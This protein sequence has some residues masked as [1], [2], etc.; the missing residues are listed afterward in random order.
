[1]IQEISTK[2]DIREYI[3]ST[4]DTTANYPTSSDC[5][6][7]STMKVIDGTNKAVVANMIFNGTTWVKESRNVQS[8]ATITLAATTVVHHAFDVISTAAGAV[9]DFTALGLT[10][11]LINITGVRVKYAGAA[12]PGAHTGYRLHLYHTAPAAIADNAAF[13]LPAADLPKYIGYITTSTLVDLGDNC[14]SID[15]DVDF[16]CRLAGTSLYGIL[17]CIAAETPVANTVITIELVTEM[18]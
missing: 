13:N 15:N 17:S 11:D 14:I 8:Q 5:G 10:G 16:A 18:L 12:I 9:L 4:G 2:K 3:C 6:P 1:M 7:G